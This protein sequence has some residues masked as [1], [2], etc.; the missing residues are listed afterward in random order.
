[1]KT[2][3]HFGVTPAIFERARFLRKHPTL[4]EEILWEQLRKNQT[5]YRFRRQHPLSKFVVHFY[6]HALKFVIELDGSVHDLEEQQL[7]DMERETELSDLGL[8]IF[9]IANREVFED[10]SEVMSKIYSKI[11][12]VEKLR[13][14]SK[15]D[16]FNNLIN[17]APPFQGAG[18]K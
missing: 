7:T 11:K 3:M 18:G 6:C 4:A 10:I 2:N 13:L 16:S 9:R 15:P 12:E 17:S 14:Q 5:R 1:M 8:Y